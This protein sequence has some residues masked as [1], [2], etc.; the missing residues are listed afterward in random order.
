MTEKETIKALRL[1]GG[2][3]ITGK[4]VRVMEFFEGVA[5]AIKALEE[6]QQYR[7]IGTVDEVKE[8][9]AFYRNMKESSVREII[10]KCAEY[11][12]IGTVKECRDAVSSIKTQKYCEK[13]HKEMFVIN[14]DLAKYFFDKNMMVFKLYDNDYCHITYLDELLEHSARGGLFGIE[15]YDLDEII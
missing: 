1:E 12:K 10:E 11:E 3:E 5:M 7:E 9:M 13:V 8:A 2:I 6:I 15:K 14:F 4:A